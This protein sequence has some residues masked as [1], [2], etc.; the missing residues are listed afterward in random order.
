MRDDSPIHITSFRS[1]LASAARLSA[2]TIDLTDRTK[3][4]EVDDTQYLTSHNESQRL[5][6]QKLKKFEEYMCVVVILNRSAEVV[7]LNNFG[8][9]LLG[10][11][12]NKAF[13]ICWL[14]HFIPSEQRS[15]IMMAFEQI[16]AGNQQ[17]YAEYYNDL[18][19]IE[20]S[21]IPFKWANS[22]LLDKDS[23]IKGTISF[24]C[25][26]RTPDSIKSFVNQ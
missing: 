20:G 1:K 11:E 23:N 22:V 3:I 7:F 4:L 2:R 25:D 6:H 15:E 14:T 12:K 21:I 26:A 13:G 9:D 18:K 24:G 16:I 5:F 10:I 8:C 19:T 17:S